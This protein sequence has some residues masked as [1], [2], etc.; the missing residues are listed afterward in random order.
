MLSV[1]FTH[2]SCGHHTHLG[3][4]NVQDHNSLPMNVCLLTLSRSLP[5]I[6]FEHIDTFALQSCC[7]VAKTCCVC[8][9]IFCL[10]CDVIA[11]SS[12]FVCDRFSRSVTSRVDWTVRAKNFIECI[13]QVTL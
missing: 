12:S 6:T 2:F 10:P 13:M 8:L 9:M 7:F 3:F 4:I 11:Y 1:T 5:P